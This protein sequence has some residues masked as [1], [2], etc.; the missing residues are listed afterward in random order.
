MHDHSPHDMSHGSLADWIPLLIIL[1]AGLIYSYGWFYAIKQKGKWST[2]RGISFSIGILLLMIAMWPELVSWAH[3]DLRGHMVQHLLIGMF[4]PI[5]LVM[6]AP[7]TLALK[8][9]SRNIANRITYVL[10][11]SFFHFISHPVIAMLL[12]IGGMYVLYLTPIY[13][14]TFEFPILHHAIHIHFL[15]AGYLFTWAII[16]PDPAPNRPRLLVRLSVLFISIAAH[17]FLSKL[18]YAHLYPLDSPHGIAEIQDA[19]KLMYY[20]GDLSE[21]ILIILLFTLWY[22]KRGR[23]HYDLTPLVKWN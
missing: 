21:L 11:S 20:W 4:A 22:R 17:A 8:T 7:I 9:V 12:N 5:F 18:M 10:R 1:L 3:L 13:N 14:A 19:A 23:P 6:G 16:G 15:L 2:A